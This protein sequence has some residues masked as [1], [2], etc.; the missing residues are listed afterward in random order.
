MVSEGFWANEINDRE[1]GSEV[2]YSSTVGDPLYLILK[3]YPLEDSLSPN[4]TTTSPQIFAK[5]MFRFVG[6]E[7]RLVLKIDNAEPDGIYPNRR[8]TSEPAEKI[9]KK[10]LPLF[11]IFVHQPLM[12]KLEWLNC[13]LHLKVKSSTLTASTLTLSVVDPPVASTL[14]VTRSKLC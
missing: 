11:P 12:L 9:V 5:Y 8:K 13:K 3:T 10:R 6:G 4:T 2:T 1:G 7:V 14:L